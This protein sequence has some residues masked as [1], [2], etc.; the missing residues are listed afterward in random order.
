MQQKVRGRLTAQSSSVGCGRET[1]DR[2]PADSELRGRE[3]IA[4]VGEK[5]ELREA[6][7]A[8][9]VHLPSFASLLYLAGFG[10]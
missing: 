9:H 8:A 6:E 2:P 10:R 7:L 3:A 4:G 5:L 1:R